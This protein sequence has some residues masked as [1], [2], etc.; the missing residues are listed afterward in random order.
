MDTTERMACLEEPGN[1]HSDQ[2]SYLI[3]EEIP[4]FIDKL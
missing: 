1:L 3:A 4:V 2:L